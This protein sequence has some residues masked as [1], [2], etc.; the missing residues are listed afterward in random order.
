LTATTGGVVSGNNIP[1]SADKLFIY[2]SGHGLQMVNGK[3]VAPQPGDGA[4]TISGD[5]NLTTDGFATG[6]S[7][8]NEE[9]TSVMDTNGNVL[10]QLQ[11]GEAVNSGAVITVPG[12]ISVPADAALVTDPTLV[13][14]YNGI[15]DTAVTYQVELPEYLLSAYATNLTVSISGLNSPY[16]TSNLVLMTSFIGGDQELA[17]N[18]LSVLPTP[19]LLIIT[20]TAT[21]TLV[22]SWPSPSTGFVLQQNSNLT[23][24]N[25]VTVPQPP[26]TMG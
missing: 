23:T 8:T 4:D 16:V 26:T 9:A 2:N 15:V 5:F 17:Y 20:P 12:V 14:N 21:N 18:N 1:G 19:P 3:R 25:W 13:Y 22:V 6:Y 10:L 24:T 11:L 7:L